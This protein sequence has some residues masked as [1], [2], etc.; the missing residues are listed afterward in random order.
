MNTTIDPNSLLLEAVAD[1]LQPILDELVLVGGC[2]IGLLVTDRA[3]PEIRTTEDVDLIT[4]ITT[5]ANYLQL[6]QK[7]KELGFK[8]GDITCRWVKANLLIDIMPKDE[9]ILGFTNVWYEL[10]TQESVERM[11][12]SGKKIRHVTA[13]LFIA[14][15]LISFQDR[16]S[17]NYQHHDIEDIVTVINS[18]VELAEEIQNGPTDVRAFIKDEFE[19]MLANIDFTNTLSGHIRPQPPQRGEVIIERMRKIAGI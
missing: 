5:Y 19:L 14:T 13:P 10:A 17:N 3:Q 6:S 7:L 2:V 12:P 11:L 15:K 4:E 8:E 16:G 9:K 18:R 1:A